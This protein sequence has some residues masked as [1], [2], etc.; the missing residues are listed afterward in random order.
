MNGLEKVRCDPNIPVP[1]VELN[2]VNHSA[3]DCVPAKKRKHDSGEDGEA[4]SRVYAL[5]NGTSPCNSFI[6]GIIGL[7][8]PK[9]VQLVEEANMVIIRR[10]CML[11]SF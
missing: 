6:G 9:V 1:E 10:T 7:V 4:G 5:P 2:H 3:G 11:Y 8:K